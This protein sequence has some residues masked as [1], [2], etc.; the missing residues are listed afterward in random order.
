MNSELQI[1]FCA[2]FDQLQS[3][4]I[5]IYAVMS[6]GNSTSNLPTAAVQGV[7]QM[8]NHFYRP[9]GLCLY[10]VTELLQL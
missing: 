9:I 10:Y 4:C 7:F 2:Q 6:K 3:C 1:I 8:D 5:Y